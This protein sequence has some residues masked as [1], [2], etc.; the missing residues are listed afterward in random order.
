MQTTHRGFT[1]IELLVVIAIIALLIGI[2]LPALGG[3]RNSAR[4]LVCL[5]NER[6]LGQ[7]LAI[8]TNANDG[9]L[10]GPNTT[11]LDLHQGR[12][13]TP[14]AESPTQDWDWISP[15]VGGMLNLPGEDR[16]EKYQRMLETEVACPANRERYATLFR[17]PQLPMDRDDPSEGPHPRIMSYTMSSAFL[18]RAWAGS[19][20]SAQPNRR[21]GEYQIQFAVSG[22]TVIPMTQ[23][24]IGVLLPGAYRPSIDRIGSPS[25]KAF[26]FEGGRYWDSSLNNGVGGLDYS[27]TLDTT[28]FVGSPQGNFTSLGPTFKG[29]GPSGMGGLARDDDGNPSRQFDELFLRHGKN[30]MNVV[31]FD[32]SGEALDDRQL[33][34]PSLYAPARSTMFDASNLLDEYR[35]VYPQNATLP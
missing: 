23:G 1:L 2:L 33:A 15:V 14:G 21:D 31:Y 16:L 13:Y 5:A 3:A 27:T 18:F 4:D 17:G 6:S 19:D 24:E 11:G 29:N 10:P 30:R 25:R 34:D 8:F 35:D 22:G 12:A 32:G 9:D 20:L 28:G 26:A 7:G